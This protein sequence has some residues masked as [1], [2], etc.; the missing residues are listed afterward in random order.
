[1]KLTINNALI[2]G[3]LI[4][5]KLVA[6]FHIVRY[7]FI[8]LIMIALVFADFLGKQIDKTT[9]LPFANDLIMSPLF[10]AMGLLIFYFININKDT[11]GRF[12]YACEQIGKRL[13][14]SSFW[15]PIFKTQRRNKK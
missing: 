15:K 3:G 13:K 9:L 5:V 12:D 6:V 2:D 14:K 4:A 1:M 11:E 8:M 7:G 10:F